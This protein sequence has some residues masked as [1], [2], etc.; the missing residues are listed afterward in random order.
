MGSWCNWLAHET[1]TLVISVQIRVDPI[2]LNSLPSPPPSKM[3]LTKTL[4]VTCQRGDLDTLQFL[5]SLPHFYEFYRSNERLESPFWITCKYGHLLLAQHLFPLVNV[6]ET[7][8]EEMTPL[9]VACQE[10]H[11]PLV[12][13]LYPLSDHQ[14]C[15][16]WAIH[17]KHIELVQWLM[18]Q[19]HTQHAYDYEL[20]TP[21]HV[22]CSIKSLPFVKLI[23]PKSNLDAPNGSDFTPFLLSCLHGCLPICQYLYTQ[24]ACIHK[25]TSFRE[26]AMFLACESGNLELVQWLHSIGAK[27]HTDIYG[28]L[29]ISIATIKGHLS[30]IPW[31]CQHSKINHKNNLGQTP[32]L[33]ACRHG[34]LAIAQL[35]HD[36]YPKDGHD[37]LP[38]YEYKDSLQHSPLYYAVEEGHERVVD[39]VGSFGIS[40]DENLFYYLSDSMLERLFLLGACHDG[41][42]LYTT[43]LLQYY[44]QTVQWKQLRQRLRIHYYQR[45]L[46]LSQ[47]VRSFDDLMYT[48]PWCSNVAILVGDYVGILRGKPWQR[49]LTQKK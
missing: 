21:L 5:T 20:N 35:L 23:C 30:L 42:R 11:L 6:T 36:L 33:L 46:L 48:L 4:W 9:Q 18:E 3:D 8:R 39:W 47:A 45:Q 24:G 17:G 19:D 44:V 7:D 26:C 41:D 37:Y 43:I 14:V 10:G 29:P 34:H 22:A 13:W 38:L 25:F 15:L 31:L 40:Y 12:Q 27:H 32:F 16:H 49:L 28:Q 2:K 1:L